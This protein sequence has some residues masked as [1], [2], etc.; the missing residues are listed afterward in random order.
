MS[1]WT[2]LFAKLLAAAKRGAEKPVRP[3]EVD[4][5]LAHDYG[6]VEEWRKRGGGI[7]PPDAPHI[8]EGDG[9]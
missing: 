6:D 1:A 8:P 3:K 2:D 4:D 9:L 7:A 5:A